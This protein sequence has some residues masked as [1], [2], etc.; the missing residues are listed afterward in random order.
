MKI[1]A[2][3]N[4]KGGVGKTKISELM[5]EYAARFINKRVLAIDF[6]P[7]CNFS[8]RY[9]AM[10]ADPAAPEGS[11]PPL[12][13]TYNIDEEYD[14]GWDGRS[15]IADIFFNQQILP[16]PTPINNLDIAPGYHSKLLTVNETRK[17]DI[18]EKIQ[19]HLNLFLSSPDIQEAYDLIVID[20]APSKGPLTIGA[21]RA[22]THIVIPAIM[23]P[24]PIE[25]IYGML[26]L[27]KQEMLRRDEGQ[28]K[29]E[30]VGILP[31]QFKKTVLHH[32]LLK[33]L[34]N[35]EQM[36]KYIMPDTLGHR[37]VFAEVDSVHE[38][39]TGARSS[40]PSVFDQ[41]DD[42]IA[43]IEAMKVCKYIMEKVFNNG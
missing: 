33:Q 1:L 38:D 29:L 15:S 37:I 34:K 43:K 36:K 31:N 18:K 3:V 20:T 19:N 7:Q 32:D 16:Y 12:H 30:L 13:H 2:A 21:I 40:I 11:M 27:W 26:Q 17:N 25:G 24:K 10:L 28:S 14:D 41:P 35:D 8:N 22:A 23:E 39:D 9:L 6:D 42:N 5:V 4:N